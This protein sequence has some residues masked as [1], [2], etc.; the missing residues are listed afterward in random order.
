MKEFSVD[1]VSYVPKNQQAEKLAGLEYV[2]VRSTSA[3]VFAGYMAHRASQT[4]TIK[5]A[6]RLWCWE[7]A[8]SLSQLAVHGVSKPEKCKFPC[9][10]ETIIVFDVIEILFV[11]KKAKKSIAEVAVWTA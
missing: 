1:G 10:V 2:I 4:V 3:G 8:A 5:Q 9:E 6:R 11:T 7:G